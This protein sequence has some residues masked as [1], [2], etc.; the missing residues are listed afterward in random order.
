MKGFEAVIRHSLYITNCEKI[1]GLRALL[2][3]TVQVYF[4]NALWVEEI[5]QCSIFGSIS[6]LFYIHM[7]LIVIYIYPM[8][9]PVHAFEYRNNWFK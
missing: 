6:L 3:N 5:E 1:L 7:R 9:T 2:A 4:G 8:T